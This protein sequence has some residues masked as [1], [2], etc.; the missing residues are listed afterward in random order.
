MMAQRIC[1]GF[2]GPGQKGQNMIEAANEMINVRR[3]PGPA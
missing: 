2:A 1:S 3:Q